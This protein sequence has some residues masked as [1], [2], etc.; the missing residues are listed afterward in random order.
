M[1]IFGEALGPLVARLVERGGTTITL[2]RDGPAG[3]DPVTG[4][5]TE[6]GTTTDVSGVIEDV[7]TGHPD[8]LVRRGDRMVSIA[9]DALGDAVEPA[10]GDAVIIQGKEFRVISVASSWAGDRPVLHRL[11]LRL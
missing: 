3:Y 10:P 4:I 8:G 6:T 5:V 9:A 7:E 1:S 11:Q 2:R